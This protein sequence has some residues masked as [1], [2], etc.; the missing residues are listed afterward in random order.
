MS[1]FGGLSDGQAKEELERVLEY[2][3]LLDFMGQGEL[4]DTKKEPKSSSGADGWFSDCFALDLTGHEFWPLS[5]WGYRLKDCKRSLTEANTMKDCAQLRMNSAQREWSLQVSLHLCEIPRDALDSGFMEDSLGADS[6]HTNSGAEKELSRENVAAAVVKLDGEGRLDDFRISPLLWQLRN[7]ASASEVNGS[8][9]DA[10]SDVV[11]RL[12][13]AYESPLTIGDV[14]EIINEEIVKAGYLNNVKA[15]IESYCSLAKKAEM[16]GCKLK[17]DKRIDSC[18]VEAKASQNPDSADED[19]DFSFGLSFFKKDLD[20]VRNEM[21]KAKSF[22]ELR[23]GPL[24]LVCDYL[25]GGY[26]DSDNVT[27][28]DIL[29]GDEEKSLKAFKDVLDYDNM[30]L[31]R[32]PS[33]YSPALMQQVAINLTSGRMMG[34]VGKRTQGQLSDAYSANDIVSVNGPPGTGKTTLL[35]DVIAANIVE[36]AYIL[37]DAESPDDAFEAIEVKSYLRYAPKMYRLKEEYDAVNDLGILV[38]S[39]NNSAVEN[40]SKELPDGKKFFEG[41]PEGEQDVFRGMDASEDDFSKKWS[42]VSG[43][44]PDLYFSYP[45]AL[46]FSDAS[47]ACADDDAPDLLVAARLGKTSNIKA[48]WNGPLDKIQRAIPGREKL[49]DSKYKASRARF[50][51]QYDLVERK[52]RDRSNVVRLMDCRNS[53]CKQIKEATGNLEM[54]NRN[55]LD[56]IRLAAINANFPESDIPGSADDVA[57][58]EMRISKHLDAR[59]SL[60]DVKRAMDEANFFERKRRKADLV[61]CEEQYRNDSLLFRVCD[62]ELAKLR[63]ACEDYLRESKNARVEIETCR[64]ELRKA[65]EELARNG[66]APDSKLGFQVGDE[67]TSTIRSD[68]LAQRKEAQ[69]FNPAP[70]PADIGGSEED[71]DLSKQRDLLFLYALQ[72]TREFVLSSASLKCNMWNL[73]CI[74]G[75]KGKAI[76]GDKDELIRYAPGDRERVMPALLQ[77]LFVVTPVVST[78]FSS[79]ARMLGDVPIS[80]SKGDKAP[81]GLLVIDEAGQAVPMAAVGALARCRKALIVGDPSQVEPVVTGELDDIRKEMRKGLSGGRSRFFSKNASVQQF[82]DERNPYGSYQEHADDAEWSWIGCPLIVHRRCISP[83]FDVSNEISYGGRMINETFDLKR[84]D[85]KRDLFYWRSSQWFNVAGSEKGNRNHYVEKQGDFAAKIVVEAFARRIENGITE[86]PSLYVISP[87]KSVKVE[88]ADYL[89]LN[90]AK[91][92]EAA[93]CKEP[94][95]DCWKKFLNDNIGTVH[96]FQGK[97]ADEVVFLLGCDSTSRGT[98][99]WVAPNVVN[100]AASRAKFRLYVVGDYE[101][102]KSNDSVKVMHRILNTAWVAHYEKWKADPESEEGKR[103]L[104]I[105]RDMLP[106]GVVLPESSDSGEA[107][108][109]QSEPTDDKFELGACVDSACAEI[110]D[111][112]GRGGFDALL[113]DEVFRSFGYSGGATDFSRELEEAF[114]ID[115]NQELAKVVETNLKEGMFLYTLFDLGSSDRESM[116]LAFCGQCFARAFEAYL[117]ALMLPCLRKAVPSHKDLKNGKNYKDTPTLGN[118]KRPIK[119]ASPSLAECCRLTVSQGVYGEDWWESYGDGVGKVLEPRNSFAHGQKLWDKTSQYYLRCM[120]AWLLSPENFAP[121]E[122]TDKAFPEKGEAGLMRSSQAFA[123][124]RVAAASGNVKAIAVREGSKDE[125][126]S[127]TDA[128]REKED[129]GQTADIAEA[130]DGPD[131]FEL[132]SLSKWRNES[133]WVEAFAP[134]K[135]PSTQKII[136]V[137]IEKGLL[138]KTE[139]GPA[140]YDLSDDLMK[141]GA[142]Q[143]KERNGKGEAYIYPVYT[144]TAADLILE[145]IQN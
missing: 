123:A 61:A 86:V 141:L 63:D 95:D 58:L 28:T 112:L 113:T 35:K 96:T 49:D 55:G 8:Y 39:S 43:Q 80:S 52:M 74:W 27:R 20:A 34:V 101:V 46:Q 40:I 67:L 78:T 115:G 53:A 89:K 92:F 133:N 85:P 26:S 114:G 36:K 3:A 127:A 41:L 33:K 1:G 50:R 18:R 29:N 104:G 14:K 82:A 69:G 60:D 77:S 79:I 71:A 73:M 62:E 48:F 129:K 15:R 68:D 138:K 124:L 122:T 94:D 4:P 84:D 117:Q 38:C 81:F 136:K 47:S 56:V 6:N 128:A 44:R 64:Q 7:G 108:S 132:M 145:R 5:A 142:K 107:K 144:K 130:S 31:G 87:F 75:K 66:Y 97:E 70:K 140:K 24:S 105:A 59:Q 2:W 76:D 16:K 119:K 37:S 109:S 143:K 134:D 10:M 57:T 139:Q 32:W 91:L 135:V 11:A 12:G 72:M 42:G 30:P 121:M 65:E 23:N 100:V 19:S 88:F 118:Y 98:V 106:C 99:E 110:A 120:I 22:E 137:L 131:E 21:R 9:E 83:M 90:K 25:L 51:K 125:A 111:A 126:A 103:E 13:E 17:Y 116:D 54:L 102:W 93:G 45:A